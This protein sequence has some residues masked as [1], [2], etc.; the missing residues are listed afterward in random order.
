MA[1]DKILEEKYSE[2]SDETIEVILDSLNQLLTE[3]PGATE[4]YP[5][6]RAKTRRELLEELFG[7]PDLDAELDAPKESELQRARRQANKIRQL[8]TPTAPRQRPAGHIK[9]R[10]VQKIIIP[11]P[12]N[13]ETPP[14]PPANTQTANGGVNAAVPPAAIGNQQNTIP[15]EIQPGRIINIPHTAVHKWRLFRIHLADGRWT[16]RFDHRGKLRSCKRR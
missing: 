15:V 3:I 14:P 8:T 11:H 7:D 6:P 5:Q 12:V 1:A 4:Q 13:I 9:I 16:L 2:M 10:P